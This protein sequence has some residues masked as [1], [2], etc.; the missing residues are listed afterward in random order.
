MRVLKKTIWPYQIF[1]DTENV[2]EPV[3]WCFEAIGQRGR[4]WYHYGTYNRFMFVF[5]NE[6]DLLI[7]KL[8]WK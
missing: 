5:K 1:L 2:R 7:F 8:K 4:A 6:E 3:L